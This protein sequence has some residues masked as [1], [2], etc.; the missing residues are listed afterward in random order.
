VC[1]RA[2]ISKIHQDGKVKDGSSSVLTVS[3][4]NGKFQ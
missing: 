3:Q 1:V 4:K 2:V